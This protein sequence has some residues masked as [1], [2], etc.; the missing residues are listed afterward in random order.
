MPHF[1][2]QVFEEVLDGQV[3]QKIIRALTEAV[4]KVFGERARSIAAVQ[5][6]GIPRSRWGVGGSVAKEIAPIATLNIREVAL[7]LP[8]V[9]S[10]INQLIGSVTDAMTEVFGEST[11]ERVLVQILGIPAGRSGVGGEPA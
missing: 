1:N 5:I 8:G 11:R 9:D 4:V 6:T 3:E 10:P 7:H 2:V